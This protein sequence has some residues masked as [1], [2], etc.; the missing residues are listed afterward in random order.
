M[1]TL[2]ILF[3]DYETYCDLNIKTAGSDA[4]MAHESL[5]ALL[6]SYGRWGEKVNVH[7]FHR[8]QHLP[9][10]IVDHIL[11][12]ARV[13][14]WSS[15][16]R[17][18]TNVLLA[19]MGLPPLAPGQY[20]DV[21]LMAAEMGYPLTLALA[22]KAL[23]CDIPKD[24]VG[25]LCI[26]TFC[27]P[28]RKG[29]RVKPTDRSDLWR[30]FVRYCRVDTELMM[31]IYAKLPPLSGPE[32]ALYQMHV[33]MN[34][35]GVCIDRRACET[36]LKLSRQI[37]ARLNEL[38]VEA[39]EGA[40]QT[41]GQV[42]KIAEYLGVHSAAEGQLIAGLAGQL[43]PALNEGKPWDKQ[44]RTVATLRLRGAKSS[45][46]KIPKML[47]TLDDAGRS[48][49]CFQF[50]G[51]KTK[52]WAGRNW[53]PQNLPRESLKPV[54]FSACLATAENGYDAFVQ[55]YPNPLEAISMCL[56]GLVVPAEGNEFIIADY[57]AIEARVLCWYA[58]QQDILNIYEEGRDVYRE[59]AAGLFTTPAEDISEGQRFVGKTLVLGS[60][61]GLG[62]AGLQRNLR[63]M[64]RATSELEAKAYTSGYRSRF[65]KVPQWWWKLA[66]IL[67][68]IYDAEVGETIDASTT[69][70]NGTV[71]GRGLT[72]SREEGDTIVIT[73]PTG[74]RLWYHECERVTKEAPW[75]DMIDVI[76]ARD[77]RSDDGRYDVTHSILAENICSATA[78][79]ILARG[80]YA[81]WQAGYQP[82]MTVH[83]EVVLEVPIGF[84]ST[85]EVDGLL[86]TRPWFAERLPLKTEAFRAPRYTK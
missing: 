71:Y 43:D 76:T 22:G 18:A 9:K 13:A 40:I 63:G 53:Q 17:L 34:D 11:K 5:L 73:L 23:K 19:R 52:R 59:T 46:A 60:G 24:P 28:N 57:S 20:I 83:D 82:V 47:A 25:R 32:T 65:H 10:S 85:G 35:Y 15:F 62:W 72:F 26:Q 84:G 48:R 37:Q 3:L 44:Q 1:K 67:N 80:M 45:T 30:D 49:G 27:K 81:C 42:A 31:E 51:T 78:R 7:E 39:T 69:L 50:C 79:E 6:L 68:A 77:Y 8:S 58:G 21:A 33:A 36:L 38:L 55:N 70:D 14:G 61:Y 29:E 41:T 12:G 16:E 2:G 56:R 4:Y 66:R 74:A 86:C 54:E 64:G 75:G